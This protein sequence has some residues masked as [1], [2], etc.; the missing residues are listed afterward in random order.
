MKKIYSTPK[1]RTVRLD[2]CSLMAGSIPGGD[3]G[4]PGDRGQAKRMD[5]TIYDE[6]YLEE[7]LDY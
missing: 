1:V 3:P 5:G 7:E 2:A 6:F 4:N